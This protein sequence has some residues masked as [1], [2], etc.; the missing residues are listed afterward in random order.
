MPSLRPTRP[1]TI[2]LLLGISLI[3]S[4]CAADRAAQ[5]QKAIDAVSGSWVNV[6]ASADRSGWR[7]VLTVLDGLDAPEPLE[8]VI[9]RDGTFTARYDS[10]DF[11]SFQRFVNRT[12][13]ENPLQGHFTL[14]VDWAGNAWIHLDPGAPERRLS[15]ERGLLTLHGVGA[16]WRSETYRRA[17][18]ASDAK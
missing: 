11:R 16:S 3:G 14:G 12:D 4:G 15:L 9:R 10:H 17:D 5:S 2:A 18:A 7:E 8:L 13:I 6:R 1:A